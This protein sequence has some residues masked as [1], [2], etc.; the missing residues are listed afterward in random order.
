MLVCVHAEG[1]PDRYAQVFRYAI[2]DRTC[3]VTR[4]YHLTPY[5]VLQES[6][7]ER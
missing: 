2:Q 3:S 1:W 4:K 7:F 5:A 6:K